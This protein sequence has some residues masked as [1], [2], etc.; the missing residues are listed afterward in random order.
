[1]NMNDMIAQ[2]PRVSLDGGAGDGDEDGGRL[3]SAAWDGAPGHEGFQ[4][5]PPHSLGW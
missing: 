5:R 1:M 4:P 3:A 2:L